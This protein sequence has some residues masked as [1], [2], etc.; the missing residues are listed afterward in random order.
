MKWTGGAKWICILALCISR[1]GA[2]EPHLTFTP[3]ISGLTQ[4]IQIVNAGDGTNRLF[5]ALQGTSQTAW[6]IV[7]DQAYN[8]LDTFLTVND[9]GTVCVYFLLI[10]SFQTEYV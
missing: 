1:A 7:Y 8:K 4:P 3:V 10:L 5:V 9:I 6:I 2:Q